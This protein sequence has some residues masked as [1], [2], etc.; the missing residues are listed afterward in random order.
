MLKVVGNG[1][2]RKS[3]PTHKEGEKDIWQRF[4][5]EFA[6]SLHWFY[7]IVVSTCEQT[8]CCSLCQRTSL[9]IVGRRDA[10]ALH[11]AL[12]VGLLVSVLLVAMTQLEIA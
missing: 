4:H 8:T 1:W 3:K 2:D 6:R 9:A 10:F 5:E 7:F 11:P 12:F